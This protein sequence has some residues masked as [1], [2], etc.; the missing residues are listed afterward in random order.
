MGLMLLQEKASES[1]FTLSLPYED[2]A[3]SSHLQ[4]RKRILIRNLKLLDFD[5]GLSSL[6]NLERINF[7]CL[8]NLG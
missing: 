5:L 1:L 8:N 3:E 6:Q 4:A 7:C 2:S